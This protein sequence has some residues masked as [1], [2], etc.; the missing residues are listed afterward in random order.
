MIIKRQKEINSSRNATM[1]R[2]ILYAKGER[3]HGL[4]GEIVCG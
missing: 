3:I 1:P 2:L 4:K